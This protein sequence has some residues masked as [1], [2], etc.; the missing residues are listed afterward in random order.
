MYNMYITINIKSMTGI[1]TAINVT[2]I[3]I[4][5]SHLF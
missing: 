1:L 4:Q 5:V 2:D 3:H